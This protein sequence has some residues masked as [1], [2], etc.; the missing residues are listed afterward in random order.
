MLYAELSPRESLGSQSLVDLFHNSLPHSV[1]N[2]WNVTRETTRMLSK[3][4]YGG[5]LCGYSLWI[6]QKLMF[7]LTN[8][9][10]Y[11]RTSSSYAQSLNM[12]YLHLSPDGHS[13]WISKISFSV[14]ASSYIVLLQSNRFSRGR[15]PLSQRLPRARVTT[16]VNE[17]KRSFT[18]NYVPY[19]DSK[20]T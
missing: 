5:A 14:H 10:T 20:W 4:P 18:L 19:Y 15:C 2:W 9:Y 12:M 1:L 8:N 16:I 7:H 3:V 17:R 13:V 6:S 11:P